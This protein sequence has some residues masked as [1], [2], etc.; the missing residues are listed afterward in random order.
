VMS[1]IRT[2]DQRLRVFVSSTLGEL[3]PERRA[4]SRALSSMRLTPVMFEAGARPHPPAELYRA[5]LEQSDVF[6]GLYWQRY[7]Q[8]VPGSTVSGL[9]E[10]FELS[11]GKPRLLYL[12]T[13]AADREP[14]LTD[15]LH[16]IERETSYRRFGT[17]AEL[18]RLV[19][20]DLAHLLSERFTADRSVADHPA[21][22]P[23][24]SPPPVRAATPLP[25][26][27]TPLFGREAVIDDVVDLLTRAKR[28][29]VTLTGP[30][31]IGKTRLATAVAE[32]LRTDFDARTLFVPLED[33]TDPEAVL[34]RVA[35]ALGADLAGAASPV[36][37]LA[38]LLNPD[39]WLLVLDNL[40]RLVAAGPGV[41]ELVA[42]SP[43][44]TVLATS[45]TELGVRA[46]SPYPVPPL[47][48]PV[49]QGAT[50][51]PELL[52]SPA[53]ALFV[54]RARAVRPG[55][56][57]TA[58]DVSAVVEIC[59]RLEGLPLAIELAAARV[60]LLDP[61]G[62]LRR[63]ARSLDALGTGMVDLPERQRTLRATVEWSLGM[64]GTSQRSLLEVLSVFSD[65]WTVEAAAR[66]AGLDE[67]RTLELTEALA[68]H[69]L[70]HLDTTATGPRPRMLRTVRAIVAERLAAR[71]D[72]E[73]VHRRH[74][75]YYRQVAESADQPLRGFRQRA[76]ADILVSENANIGLAV[77][78]HLGHDPAPLPRLFRVLSPFRIL[79]PFLGLGDMLIG[80]ARAW[81]AELLP[82]VDSLSP[83][84]RAE[85][86]GTALVSALEVGDAGAARAASDRLVP[87]LAEADDPYL[88]AVS[89]LLVA[90]TS[91]L[92]RDVDGAGRALAGA[93]DRLRGLDEP[94]WTALAL[95]TAGSVA[96]ARGDVD[97]AWRHVTEAQALAGRFDTPWLASVSRVVMGS[98]AVRRR[99]FDEASELLRQALDLSLAGGSTHCLC[100]V[101]DCSAALALAQ[102][103]PERAGLLA[104][105][106]D[107]LRRR[108]G[109]RVYASMRGDRDLAAAVRRA[110]GVERFDELFATGSRLRRAD[111]L[112]LARDGLR[113]SVA[114]SR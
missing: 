101:L 62:V 61:A 7:G 12:K 43:G 93:L 27:P 82:D 63:L 99:S 46:E 90:W 20:D 105:A 3:A 11:R 33:V 64:L 109:L 77:R 55:F 113:A 40:E 68:R 5:Y 18:G 66:V 80:E 41:A 74:A 51:L 49:D 1:G 67:D 17:P 114:S 94:M 21:P 50:D 47:P 38:D 106:A 104:G 87:L 36:D 111:V 48:V 39:R 29:L 86:L 2:P 76:C 57:P 16:R 72:A 28:R 8:L 30:S 73:E 95:V 44:V 70:L 15:L 91:V 102:G 13:P 100:L 10:E 60:R 53:V 97:D 89:R 56:T 32:R 37:A 92:V 45:T 107:G 98:L 34:S 52:E 31:G 58:D 69:S 24:S 81:V 103:D 78:W 112:D 108:S 25:V 23:R 59:R 6:L 75:R 79:W 9:E 110:T 96:A 26:S 35:W 19:R 71:P 4:V 54:D 84:D 88:D 14:R 83:T 42:R 85:L 22:T 65:G